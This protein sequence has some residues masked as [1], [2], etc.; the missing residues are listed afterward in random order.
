MSRFLTLKLLFYEQYDH[1]SVSCA[2]DTLQ[3][4]FFGDVAWSVALS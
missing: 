2:T 4:K 3:V 1:I